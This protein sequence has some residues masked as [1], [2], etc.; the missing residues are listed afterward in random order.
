MGS[1]RRPFHDGGVRAVPPEILHPEVRVPACSLAGTSPQEPLEP[2][3]VL[4]LSAP[5][6]AQRWAGTLSGR[7]DGP[8]RVSEACTSCHGSSCACEPRGEDPGI[9]SSWPPLPPAEARGHV[10]RLLGVPF[11]ARFPRAVF[12]GTTGR[13][14]M[15]QHFSYRRRKAS[16][17]APASSATPIPKLAVSLSL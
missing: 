6:Q 16:K 9:C 2:W 8:S 7:L 12:L 17:M 3:C 4:G 11:S 14:Q 5:T 13:V 1:V 10:Y 15:H